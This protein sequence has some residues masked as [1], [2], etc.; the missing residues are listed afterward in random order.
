[1]DIELETI[2][3]G[4]SFMK[5]HAKYKDTYLK[6]IQ[7]R[8]LHKRFYTHE[9]LHKIKRANICSICR[10]EVDSVEHMFFNSE[11]SKEL[12]GPVSMTG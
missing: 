10:N 6:Y 11:V 8:T 3:L 5:H 9:K 2:I 7:F 1:M 4:R 12:Y